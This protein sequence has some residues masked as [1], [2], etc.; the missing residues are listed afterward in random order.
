[1]SAKPLM[2]SAQPAMSETKCVSLVHLAARVAL[3]AITAQAVEKLAWVRRRR[4]S[5]WMEMPGP[6]RLTARR[7]ARSPPDNS[8]AGRWCHRSAARSRRMH[9]SDDDASFAEPAYWD[10]L[11]SAVPKLAVGPLRRP[12]QGVALEESPAQRS[13]ASE[14]ARAVVSLDSR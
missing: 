12:W 9:R 6:R 2:T 11:Y 8:S 1:M 5:Y 4:A 14:G 3:L 7:C 13:A 10:A